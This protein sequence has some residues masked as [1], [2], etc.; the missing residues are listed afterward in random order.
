MNKSC[1]GSCNRD[2][3][4]GLSE[5]GFPVEFFKGVPKVGYDTNHHYDFLTR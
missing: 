1:A 5:T 2:H 4:V 3:T